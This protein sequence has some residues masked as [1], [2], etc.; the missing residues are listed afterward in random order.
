MRSIVIYLTVTRATP[1]LWAGLLS[2]LSF[3]IC[4]S[5]KPNDDFCFSTSREEAS[6]AT[7]NLRHCGAIDRDHLPPRF[8]P[9]LRGR[10]FGP[11]LL[12][13]Y[14]QGCSPIKVQSARHAACGRG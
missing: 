5:E 11:D 8:Q 1:Q 7:G 12:D 9:A 14:L 2:L 10:R 4:G 6:N 13:K 3:S